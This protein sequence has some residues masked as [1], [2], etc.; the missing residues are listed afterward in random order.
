MKYFLLPILL[1]SCVFAAGILDF[2][3]RLNIDHYEI[4]QTHDNNSSLKT[5][6]FYRDEINM[7]YNREYLHSDWIGN[8]NFSLEKTIF[9]DQELVELNNLSLSWRNKLFLGDVYEIFTPYSLAQGLKGIVFKDYLPGSFFYS[10]VYGNNAF[11]WRDVY[12]KNG[13]STA[14]GLSLGKRF[15]R[16]YSQDVY[17]IRAIDEYQVVNTSADVAGTKLRFS[18]LRQFRLDAEYNS[19]AGKANI[20]TQDEIDYGYAWKTK[21]RWDNVY[22]YEVQ[23]VDDKYRSLTG[24]YASDLV[25]R[26]LSWTPRRFNWLNA[27]MFLSYEKKNNNT[28]KELGNT[29][30]TDYTKLDL[31]Y[32]PQPYNRKLVMS[33]GF[34]FRNTL[35][36]DITDH[37]TNRSFTQTFHN[38]YAGVISNFNFGAND[39]IDNLN[40]DNNYVL[41]SFGIN[42]DAPLGFDRSYRLFLGCNISNKRNNYYSAHYQFKISGPLAGVWEQEYLLGYQEYQYDL[43]IDSNYHSYEL[44]YKIVSE[45]I[46]EEIFIELL[47]TDFLYYNDHSND[48]TD[49]RISFGMANKF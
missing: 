34:S 28:N 29:T 43:S 40:S 10:I 38:E 24:S 42:R 15:S 7:D 25:R 18:P 3:H 2:E 13:F 48:Y 4:R 39:Y 47:T 8:L 32:N 31:R 14:Q 44:G 33:S 5:G 35:D 49:N 1:V 27:Q 19:S 11:T 20:Q 26:K 36:D 22:A 6:L 16:Y 45:I 23:N 46:L 37:N 21:M 41:N 9:T 12:E 30:W 17:F